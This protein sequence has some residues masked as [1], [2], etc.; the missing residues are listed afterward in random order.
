LLASAEV[1]EQRVM[2]IIENISEL[3]EMTGS[4]QEAIN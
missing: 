4:L 2:G 3:N 1:Q